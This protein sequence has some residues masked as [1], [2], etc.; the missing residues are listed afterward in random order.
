MNQLRSLDLFEDPM[1]SDFTLHLHQ[2]PGVQW[3][4]YQE[5]RLL[6][7]G[8]IAGG[9]LADD[10]GTGKT[11]E[12]VALCEANL[13]PTTL[14][15]A[16]SNIITQ[17][18][19]E[20]LTISDRLSVFKIEDRYF[21]HVT[22]ND[23]QEIISRKLKK[24]KGESFFKPGVLVINSETLTS[25]ENEAL[26]N[27]I[28]WYRIII[29][30][31]HILRNGT[32]TQ[33]YNSLMN[34]RQPSIEIDGIKKR[35]G[36]RFAVT[37]TPIQNDIED[38]VWIFRI[39]DNRL[40]TQSSYEIN[41]LKYY[42]S[43]GLFR[44]NKDQISPYLKQLMKF[45]E[46]PPNIMMVDVEFADTDC[47]RFVA[48]QSSEQIYDLFSKDE[49]FHNDLLKDE[50]A[51]IIARM[52]QTCSIGYK[53]DSIINQHQLLSEPFEGGFHGNSYVGP[54]SKNENVKQI[55][56]SRRGQSFVIF[57]S[58]FKVRDSLKPLLSS[59]FQEY[60]FKEIS[61][62][63]KNAS[64]RYK[65]LMECNDLIS[66][67]YP[68]ILYSSIS[69]TA[70]GLNYQAFQNSIIMDQGANPQDEMQ[71]MTRIYRI[72]QLNEVNI[73]IMSIKS[74]PYY[75]GTISVDE[76]LEELKSIKLPYAELIDK[77]NAA[78]F[79]VRYYITLSDGR[80]EC[81]VIFDEEFEKLPSG[82]GGPNSVGPK[83]IC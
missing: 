83:E 57:H 15:I 24:N 70:E 65:I 41:A 73:W 16:P 68:V 20:I 35:L 18:C 59:Y 30:E 69:S 21:S 1:I 52:A 12:Y 28:E 11:R 23:N 31:A 17:I 7:D 82:P 80:R 79:F 60:T 56:S 46:K 19:V 63:L 54:K 71:A 32:K 81:G 37:G 62:E 58:F 78:W 38:I 26:I 8:C 67:G 45:P 48:T 27:S 51:F 49:R 50:K 39:I 40:F 44:R 29:D 43:I 5:N 47:S 55:I 66:R 13:V 25:S 75:Y 76:R 4:R 36:S 42:I 33:F 34:V 72:G 3:M 53:A 9:I 2:A 64:D 77:N 74:I 10:M 22:L 6:K 61:G 14:I